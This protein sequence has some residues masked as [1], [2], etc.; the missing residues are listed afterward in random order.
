MFPLIISTFKIPERILLTPT[1]YEIIRE[2]FIEESENGKGE[3]PKT[4]SLV[5]LTQRTLATQPSFIIE[6]SV[7]DIAPLDE[8]N[9]NVPL[10]AN[11][12]K[13][14]NVLVDVDATTQLAQ[15]L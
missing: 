1:Q 12:N 9:A 14:P 4:I 11:R 5:E 2:Y 10:G 6:E 7:D 13:P 8:D 15:D 3:F